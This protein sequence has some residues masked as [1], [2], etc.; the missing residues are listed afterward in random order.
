MKPKVVSFDVD[1]TLVNQDFANKFWHE[2]VPKLYAEKHG[3]DFKEA[4]DYVRRCYAEVGEEDIRWY[5]P[6]YWFK[7]FKLDADPKEVL[8]NLR[9][10]LK[11]YDDAIDALEE[12]YGKYELIVTSNASR[13]FLDVELEN[14]KDYFSRVF[15]CV[16]D[17]G[18][19]RKNP[20]V[21]LKICKQIDVHPK[22]IVHVGDHYKFDY[23]VPK[24]VGIDAYLVNRD[25]TVRVK[26]MIRDLKD[27]CNVLS[28]KV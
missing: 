3:V 14:I 20:E 8:E 24:S 18:E 4:L 2:V 13:I 1:G 6:D 9:R 26:K 10:D 16:S 21:Y 12:L 17:F 23:L 11:I 25:Q 15:S 27:F 5:L 28:L 19:V 22:K 7:R